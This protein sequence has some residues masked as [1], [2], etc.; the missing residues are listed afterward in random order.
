MNKKRADCRAFTLIELLIVLVVAAVL[1]SLVPPLY[2][3]VVPAA[4]V[5]AAALELA[6]ELREIR[7][8]AIRGGQKIE[9]R[10]D[11]DQMT[12]ECADGKLANLPEG[13]QLLVANTAQTRGQPALVDNREAR[14]VFFPDGS[15]SGASVILS[16]PSAVWRIDIDWLTGRLRVTEATDDSP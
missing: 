7:Y 14:I 16:N 1:T 11:L 8:A 13:V 15:S 5:E 6:L 3:A 12:Y 2:S 9:L 4:R 10:F